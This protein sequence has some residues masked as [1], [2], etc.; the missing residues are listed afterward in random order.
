MFKIEYK[1]IQ[2]RFK[3]I[4]IIS[5]EEIQYNFILGNLVLF[6]SEVKI[7]MEWEWIP[8]LDFAY[9]LKRIASNLQ[10][11]DISREYFEFTENA[12]TLEFLR[13]GEQVRISTSFSSAIIATTLTEFGVAIDGFHFAISEYI[14]SNIPNP[15]T[16]ALQKY[17][18]NT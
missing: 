9:C 2:E 12:E 16:K 4:E 3:G 13:E 15:P 17:L 18:F 11:S 8:L 5:E 10:T 6:S 7:D 1:I 14:R